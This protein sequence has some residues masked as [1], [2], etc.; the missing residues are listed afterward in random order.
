[1]HSHHC[2]PP[3]TCIILMP[4][5]MSLEVNVDHIFHKIIIPLAL[6]PITKT[7]FPSYFWGSLDGTHMCLE[8]S[9]LA[10]VTTC[11]FSSFLLNRFDY[12]C[13]K[14]LVGDYMRHCMPSKALYCLCVCAHTIVP[15]QFCP[16]HSV[17]LGQ[18]NLLFNHP[19]KI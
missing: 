6:F 18:P 12:T 11:H 7:I 5:H 13:S 14:M 9:V 15:S 19:L 2:L 10:T 1:M 17:F 4:G 3:I 8:Y 16:L